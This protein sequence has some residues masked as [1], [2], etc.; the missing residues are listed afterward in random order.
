[1]SLFMTLEIDILTKQQPGLPG[2][3]RDWAPRSLQESLSP[4]CHIGRLDQY[5]PVE[6]FTEKDL[7]IWLNKS[8]FNIVM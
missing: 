6:Q 4:L 8:L 7:F 1:M 5:W 2:S 3:L